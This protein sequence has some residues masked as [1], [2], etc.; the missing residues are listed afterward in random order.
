VTTAGDRGRQSAEPLS[1]LGRTHQHPGHV[2]TS[3]PTRG[4]LLYQLRRH[5]ITVGRCSSDSTGRG[6]IDTSQQWG[7]VCRRRQATEPTC[8]PEA[9][10]SIHVRLGGRRPPSPFGSD[11]AMTT[12]NPQHLLTPRAALI[13]LFAVITGFTIGVLDFLARKSVP[14]AVLAGLGAF[15]VSIP[16]FNTLIGP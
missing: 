11:L 12:Q 14:E 5:P 1:D 4:W 8:T 13:I 7:A 6:P 10:I 3:H 16:V 15:G 9:Q 2:T